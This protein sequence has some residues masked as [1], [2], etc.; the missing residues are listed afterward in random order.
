MTQT[1]G[2]DPVDIRASHNKVSNLKS[3]TPFSRNLILFSDRTQFQLTGGDVLTPSTV[4][5]S[6]ETEFEV[7]TTAD[8][9]VSGTS[10]YFPFVRGSYSGVM[11]YFVSPDTEQMNGNDIS[12]HIP[13]YIS[14][15]ITKMASSSSDPLVV[16]TS[17]GLT[18]GFYVY[19]YLYRGRERIQSS[20]SK[21][22][23][24]S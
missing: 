4:S 19:R 10:I 17:S 6:Q 11:E 8:S 16:L 14:G 2:T 9:T 20:W 21:F 1:L 12:A 7:D 18:N 15:N 5:I 3:A 22:T 13:K 23:I 24:D